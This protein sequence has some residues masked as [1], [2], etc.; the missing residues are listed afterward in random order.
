MAA[1]MKLNITPFD[2]QNY[3]NWEF[4]VKLAMEQAGVNNVLEEPCPGEDKQIER[5]AWLKSDVRARNIIVQCLA[6]NMLELIKNKTTAKDILKSLENTY[7]KKGIASQVMQRKKFNSLSYTEDKPL[8]TF[9]TEFEQCICQ[10][11]AAG[12]NLEQNEIVAQLLS[13]M[14]ESYANI[15]TALDVIFS[16]N[17][18][19]IT[20]DFVKNKLLLEESR[21]EK[22]QIN[23][24]SS[25]FVAQ[26]KNQRNRN[27][28]GSSSGSKSHSNTENKSSFPYR[29][30]EC[31][32]KGHKRIDCP[33]LKKK[34]NKATVAKQTESSDEEVT[35]MTDIDTVNN[36]SFIS[37]ETKVRFVVDSGCTN[38]L[39]NE[40]TGNLMTSLKTVNHVI[41]VAKKG[42]TLKAVKQGDLHLL[43]IEEKPIAIRD[44]WICEN[45]FYNLLSVRKL[46]ENGLQVIFKE[47]KVKIMKGNNTVVEGK[48]CGNL[49]MITLKI[50]ENLNATWL[51]HRKMGHTCHFPA[52]GICDVCMKGK[53]TR[54]QFKTI[55]DERKPKRILEC[56]SSDVVGPMNPETFDGKRYF[57]TFI[58]HY[59]HFGSCFLIRNKSEVTEIFKKYNAQVTSKFGSK[60]ERLRCDNGGEYV[61]K[62][63]Q[64]FCQD[65][66]IHI[67]Y[68][69]ARNPEQN[70]V[71]ERYNRT[72][73]DKARC[74]IFDSKLSNDM[75]GEAVRTAIYLTNRTKTRVL[76]NDKIPAELW[77]GK[78]PDLNKIKLFGCTAY[79]Y[80]PKED[81]KSKLDPR[82][83]K[84]IMV[85]YCDNGYRLWDPVL[86]KIVLGRNVIFDEKK[87]MITVQLENADF[88]EK[89]TE[90]SS[91][92]SKEIPEKNGESSHQNLSDTDNNERNRRMSQRRRKIPEYLKDY[93][94]NDDFLLMTAL[95]TGHLT[96]DVPETYFEAIKHE[97][98]RKAIDDELRSLEESETWELVEREPETEVI[99]SKWVFREKLM[100]GKTVKRARLVARGFKQT[101]PLEENI[102][103][104]VARMLTVRVLLA[105]YLEFDMC[106][107]QLDVNSAFLYGTL[108]NPVFMEQPDGLNKN[109]NLIC[110][111]KKSLYGLKQAP[112]CWNDLFDKTL[113]NL[114]LERS[115]KD[116]C[117]Y[118]NSEMFVLIYVDDILLFSKSQNE[119]IYI[120]MELAKNFKI[121]EF[122]NDKLTFLGL[123]IEHFGNELHISQTELISKVL[124]KFN[125]ADIKPCSIPMQPKLQL[126]VNRDEIDKNLPY[127]ELIGCLMYIMLGSRPDLSFCITYFSQF[128]NNY[129]QTHW[130]YL[131]NVL[132]YLQETKTFG[133]KYTK[134]ENSNIMIKAFVD[135]DF[136]N[137]ISDRKSITGFLIKLNNN[138]VCWKTKKQNIVT[139]S[140]CEAEYIA[141]SACITEN[142]FLG[143]LIAEIL[144][145]NMYPIHIYEDN[146]SC[147]KVAS[148][149]ETK[150]SKHID[151]KHHFIRDCISQNKIVLEY[152]QTDKQV[153]DILTKGLGKMKFS[154]FRD[155]L[156]VF[157]L[158]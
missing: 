20:L 95:S 115:K 25:A 30:H 3:S 8:S 51:E 90:K 96:S 139:I 68:T 80:V 134:S 54:Q 119:L 70:G 78:H 89:K 59:S 75:W 85:G 37:D 98:W 73:L 27:R 15:V 138:V 91:E 76:P 31:G 92:T 108:D 106:V 2:G 94:L 64:K 55:P 58:D 156:N 141:L 34:W 82:S 88:E 81:R 123:E 118:F 130:K 136:A 66:G 109:P 121:K 45:L 137:N 21:R 133:L 35:F 9:L 40:E 144:K 122:K 44:A 145:Q 71:A 32:V 157:K 13:A 147:I 103:A 135:S 129:S 114:G 84:M 151:I 93:D 49:Y 17:E 29:C 33:K 140:S 24:E 158:H 99:D 14:P 105:L 6:D 117:L 5:S 52:P 39:V 46:E 142:L 26:K 22:C 127:R 53:Q 149:L 4:R 120:K 74:L 63:L 28:S 146:Q 100:N 16:Q 19:S 102:Y 154:Y 128:Q 132:R 110:K 155:C 87:E 62:E 126:D 61:S 124:D 153:A 125:M 143:Q 41:N 150:R 148:T 48:L 111:L 79:N 1:E 113:T 116:P 101:S 67:Q 56:I 60:I 50:P 131:K 69:I 152:I 97:G 47:K 107:L 86:R 11:K 36:N 42:E 57:V 83:K 65:E 18:A 104:P 77:F 23:G 43:S 38:H 7:T 10:F 72:I 12:G 112:K